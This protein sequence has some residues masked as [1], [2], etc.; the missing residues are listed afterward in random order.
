MTGSDGFGRRVLLGTFAAGATAAGAGCLVDLSGDDPEDA[1]DRAQVY[2]PTFEQVE[3]TPFEFTDDQRCAV[4]SMTP[5]NY[6]RRRGQLVHEN[7]AAAVFDSPGCLFAYVVS[8][9]PDSPV[10]G[11]WT[12]D[13][14]T[15]D[16][17]DATGAHF[18]LIT[19]ADAADDPMGIDPRPFADREDALAFLEEWEAEDLTEDDVIVGLEAV[20]LEIASIYRGNRLPDE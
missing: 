10:A 9:T 1:D 13:Y 7:G 20:D 11:A 2:E 8:S 12:T 15:R 19:D 5:T 16:L 14:G 3:E 4:C 17:I 18:V 6:P